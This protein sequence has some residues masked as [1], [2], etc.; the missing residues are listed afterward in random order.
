MFIA[1]TFRLTPRI[2]SWVLALALLCPAPSSAEA[3]TRKPDEAPAPLG[4]L[5]DVGGYRVHLYCTGS[6]SPT[7]LI[8]GAGPSFAWGLVQ[9]ETSKH[10]RVCAY[11]HSGTTW[12]DDGPPDSCALRINEAHAAL[13]Q[14]D[15][16]DSLIL[17][18][19]SVGG[20]IARLYAERFPNDIA[21]VVFVDHAFT[22]DGP[23]LQKD[24]SA[25]TVA[26]P[27][28][29]QALGIES[30]ANF[31]R[32]PAQDQALQLWA[33]SQTRY[34]RALKTSASI[35]AG[36]EAEL[37][38]LEAK[39]EYP[40][41]SVPIVDV[42]RNMGAITEYSSLQSRLLSLS[43]NSKE[44]TAESSS[45]FM[46]IDSPELILQAISDVLRSSRSG[47]QLNSTPK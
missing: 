41:G 31:S 25:T 26:P 17:V 28:H 35:A 22:I 32:L 13:K 43:R 23:S 5:V 44:V 30:D 16:K 33:M 3:Q 36:C 38:T 39:S 24:L 6:G 27:V 21:G 11:D 29:I 40:L 20:L 46:M 45:H 15:V 14:L 1:T 10:T 8:L 42:D 18:G 12:S 47:T 7:V 19:H 34:Q 4:K 2:A 9:P 37:K